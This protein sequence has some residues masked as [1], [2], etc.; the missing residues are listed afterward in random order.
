LPR[1][2]VESM[3]VPHAQALKGGLNRNYIPGHKKGGS[4]SYYAVMEQ[5]PQFIDLYRSEAFRLMLNRLTKVNLLLCPENDPH[6]CALYYYTEAGDHIGYHYDTS[7]YKG[8]RYTV[9]MG[10]LDRSKQCRLVCDLFKD[11]PGKQP[12]HL[13]LATAPGDLVLFNGDKLWHA[14]TPLGEQEERIVLTMEY[15]TNPDM[16]PFKRLY[17]NL[18]DSFG[19]FGLRS[20][21]KRTSVPRASS[22]LS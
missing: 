1:E 2:V 5:A 16:G 21:F 12:I 3:L 11:V 10:L 18:K 22:K 13:E 20:V 6:S 14:V 7:Y 15:V 17:S 8:A 9:L 4:V 19:Y